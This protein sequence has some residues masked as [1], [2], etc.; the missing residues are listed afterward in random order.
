MPKYLIHD[1]GGRPFMVDVN[2]IKKSVD[3]YKPRKL[4][5]AEETEIDNARRNPDRKYDKFQYHTVHIL[6]IPRYKKIFIG[7]DPAWKA[8]LGNSILVCVRDHEYISIGMSIYRFVT[9]DEIISY[10]SPV[11]GS[12]VP[13]P[14]AVGKQYIYFIFE[15]SQAP[16]SEFDISEDPYI[17]FYGSCDSQTDKN[18]RKMHELWKSLYVKNMKI[19][20]LVKRLW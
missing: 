14:Y 12:D 17:K 13:C 8:A 1:N 7:E 4:T 5:E 3:V 2:T 11:L 18:K 6:H 16:I 20:T 19:K 9:E 10:F 15:K